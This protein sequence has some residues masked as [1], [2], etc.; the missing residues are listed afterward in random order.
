MNSKPIQFENENGD[1]L[2]AI[3]DFPVIGKPR[4]FAIFAHCFTCNKNLNAVRAISRALSQSQIAVLSFDFTGLGQSEGEFSETNF[5][6]NIQDLISA[7]RFLKANYEAPEILIGHSLGGAAVL[8]AAN[9]ID[10]IKAVSTIGAPSHPEHIERLFADNTETLENV[11]EAT[12]SI[13]GRPFN[14][15]KQFLE[16]IRNTDLSF[17]KNKN[18]PSLLIFHSPQ[19]SIVGIENARK[20][21][22]KA[23]HPKSFISLDGADHLL[24][25][26]DD[27]YYAGQVISQWAIRYLDREI[28]KDIRTSLQVAVRT[29][30][31]S[32]TT[33]ITN[34]K[35]TWI[36]DEPKDVGGNDYGPSPYD[37]L[38][39][40]LGSCT[41]LTLKLYMD[42]KGWDYGNIEVHLNHENVHSED[43]KNNDNPSGKIDQIE[44][45]VK[46]S[47][48]FSEEQKSKILEIADKCPVHRTLHSPTVVDTKWLSE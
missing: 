19:D 23:H 8:Y 32:F 41:S 44:R 42:R 29:H 47:G 37:L 27:A 39:S 18:N 12:V 11:G 14:I 6:S 20:I 21:Y 38:L 4:H 36:A 25:N 26:K 34:G 33:E 5:S 9:L 24:S 28:S 2:S 3:I 30:A 15:K 35:H 13:G 43:A 48:N 45:L 17:N 10:S 7:S 1:S 40:S 31:D 16:D 46:V 22:E